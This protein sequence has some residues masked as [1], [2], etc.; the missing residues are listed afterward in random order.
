[1]L[2]KYPLWK[3]LLIL[4][5]VALA[6]IYAAPNLYP[7]DA[8]IQVTPARAGAEMSSATLNNVREALDDAGI[9]YF[10]EEVNGSTAL[11]RLE[12]SDAQLPAKSAIQRK[13]GD[14]FVVALNLAPTTPDWLVN[15]GAGPMTLGLDLSGGVHFLMEVDMDEYV[16]GRITN[17]RED[18]RTSLRQEDIKYRR[19]VVEGTKVRLSFRQEAL[20]SEAR[21]FIN[22]NYPGEFLPQEEEV[23]G[24]F[25]LILMLTEQKV[26]DFEDYALKQNLMT[27]RNRV[28]ELGVAEPLVQR[29]GRN[30]IVVELP[31]VQDTA[32]AKKILGK[33]ANLEFRLEAEP[34][35]SRFATEEYSFRDN[36]NRT[37]R[38][39]KK[40]ITTGDSVTN[41]SSG[42]DENSFPQVNISLDSKGAARMTQVTK[43]AVQ[44]RMA[45]LFVERKPKTTYEMVDGVEQPKTIQVVEKSIISLATIQSVLGS[46]FRITGLQSAEANELALLL[47]SGALAAPMDFVEERTVGP[48]LGAENI[49]MGARSVMAGLALVLIAMLVFYRA[50]GFIANIALAVNLVL[51][52]ALMSIIGATLTLPGIAGIV[53]TVGMAVDANVLIFSR[54]RE[55]LK[56]G[57]SPQQAIHE[58]YDRAFLTIFDANLTTLIVAVILFAVGTGPVKGFAVTL[59]FGILTSMFT[60]VMVTRAMTNLLYGGRRVERLSIG[61][62]A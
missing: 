6:F 61:G 27:L 2:N 56:N 33:A 29:Q 50:F 11:L 14:E 26:R 62:K 35:A 12:S 41:A 36:Q 58:G 23:D 57:R 45:V 52:V 59:S 43:K 22:R 39:E 4:V 32:E 49:E 8:A 13:L 47:R 9:S 18:L 19:V 30:R 20:R 7:P 46:S 31:G 25:D 28:N 34:G 44:R 54:I 16:S 53:L 17:Y 55:E 1:M 37:A 60:A 5:V 24:N 40:V 15:L 48:S 3:N 38:L 42:F 21:T 10:G 51:L